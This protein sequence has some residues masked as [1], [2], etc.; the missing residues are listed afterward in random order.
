MAYWDSIRPI[1]LVLEEQKTYK[2]LDSLEVV[3]KDPHYLDSLDK[4]RNKFGVMGLLLTGLDFGHTKNKSSFSIN[5][6]IRSLYYNTVEGGVL[7]LAMNYN[8]GYKGRESISISPVIRYG[9]A[10]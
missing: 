2:K 8:K 6:L 1:P 10:N 7:Q 3:R 5:P 9:M 4:R